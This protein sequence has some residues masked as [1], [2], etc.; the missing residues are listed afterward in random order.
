MDKETYTNTDTHTH[1]MYYSGQ[2]VL[3]DIMFESI[4]YSLF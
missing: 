1:I 4:N 2:I 3:F